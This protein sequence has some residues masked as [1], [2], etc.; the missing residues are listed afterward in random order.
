MKS[1]VRELRAINCQRSNLFI[2]VLLR[3]NGLTFAT[4][5]RIIE[6]IHLEIARSDPLF[7]SRSKTVAS[8][9]AHVGDLIG[10]AASEVR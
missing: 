9:V 5:L 6:C 2:T 1:L 8:V 3:N 10:D 4:D 7:S